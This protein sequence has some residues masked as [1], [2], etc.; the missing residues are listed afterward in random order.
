MTPEVAIT[1]L[2]ARVRGNIA[3]SKMLWPCTICHQQ[4]PYRDMTILDDLWCCPGCSQRCRSLSCGCVNICKEG[5]DCPALRAQGIHYCGDTGCD[6]GCGV[7]WCGCID[8]CRGRCG[9]N[10]PRDGW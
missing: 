2:Q 9:V 10:N 8:I 1:K 7:L 3:R 6:G 4:A 5:Y